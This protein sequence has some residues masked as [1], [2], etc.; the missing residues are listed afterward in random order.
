M[1]AGIHNNARSPFKIYTFAEQRP[2]SARRVKQSMTVKAVKEQ[3]AKMQ[4]R[5]AGGK[6]VTREERLYG[7][8]P[9]NKTS[10]GA[11]VLGDKKEEGT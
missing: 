4:R 6:G 10:F 3:R 1:C 5:E 8:L 9:G 2:L 11:T 7:R